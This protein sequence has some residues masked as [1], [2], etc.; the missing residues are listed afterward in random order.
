MERDTHRYY[1]AAK[2]SKDF[3]MMT[4]KHEFDYYE[5]E[6]YFS[7]KV[8]LNYMNE[9]MLQSYKVFESMLMYEYGHRDAYFEDRVPK[10]MRSIPFLNSA[11]RAMKWLN[12]D[13]IYFQ[14]ADQII[15]NN[16]RMFKEDLMNTEDF[17]P[18]THV[19]ILEGRTVDEFRSPNEPYLKFEMDF[20]NMSAA[21]HR[22]VRRSHLYDYSGSLDYEFIWQ[23][24]DINNTDTRRAIH[25]TVRDYHTNKVI[26]DE[27]GPAGG[28]F[29]DSR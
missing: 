25:I 29:N 10:R 20:D 1:W 5:V 22:L 19:P 12:M 18:E 21:L 13:S 4:G 3:I 14:F 2:G 26:T 23:Q 15:H 9:M 24:P 8:I 6:S 27:Y 28:E 16:S 11:K 7:D 17:R